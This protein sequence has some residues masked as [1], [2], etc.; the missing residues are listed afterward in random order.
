MIIYRITKRRSLYM[1][2]VSCDSLQAGGS[3]Q[4]SHSSTCVYGSPAMLAAL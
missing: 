3:W 2:L 1:L 4:V